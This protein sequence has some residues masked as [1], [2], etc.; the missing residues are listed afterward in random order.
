MHRRSWQWGLLWIAALALLAF[1]V[2][3]AVIFTT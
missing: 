2:A 1:F 3:V